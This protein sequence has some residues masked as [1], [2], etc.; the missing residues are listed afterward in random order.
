MLVERERNF[1]D[2]FRA[3]AGDR[4]TAT[5]LAHDL[6]SEAAT[7]GA[8]PLSKLAAELEGAC[9][10]GAPM[11]EINAMLDVVLAALAPFLHALQGNENQG[12]ARS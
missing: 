12:P 4:V 8:L 7:L 11:Q 5:R 1:G 10:R 2:R 3:A 6:K 9:A